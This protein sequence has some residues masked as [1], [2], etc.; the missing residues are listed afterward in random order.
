M[1]RVYKKVKL[2]EYLMLRTKSDAA[3]QKKGGPM[4]SWNTRSLVLAGSALLLAS[5]AAIAAPSDD[6]KALVE[7]GKAG[8]AY[9]LGKKNAAQFGD[10]GFDFY[11][12]IAAVDSG[13]AG[14]GVLALER[15][16]LNYPDNVSARLQLARGYY[17]LGEDARAREE[18][19]ALQKL[20]PPADVAATIARF[21][22]AI[23]LR[24][25][26]YLL[27]AG[28][29]LDLGGGNDSN[30][31]GGVA[32]ADITL[33]NLGPVTVDQ[34]GQKI[35]DNFWLLGLGGYV[36][37]PIA[38]G[39]A[40]FANGQGEAR[41]NSDRENRAFDLGNYNV[42]GGV[43]LLREQ[44]LFRF[45]V[46]GNVITL[47]N[48]RYR[49]SSGAAAEW[50]YQVDQVQS[51]NLGGQYAQL[52]YA[53]PNRVRDAD[54][55]GVSAG[56][57]RLFNNTWQ[58][59]FSLALNGGQEKIRA[60]DRDDLARKLFGARAGLNFTPAAKWGVSAG[61]T[62]LDSKYQAPDV[63]LGVSR[64]DKYY[65]GDAAIVY[66]FTRNLSFHLEALW[67]KNDSNIELYELPRNVYLFKVRYEFK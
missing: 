34:R 27:S 50:Q 8:E 47:D 40:L 4:R 14:E 32:N 26:R 66:L 56:Y 55:W 12:G 57:R 59:V 45:S 19:E 67:S 6:V 33:P 37:K 53:D 5:M 30:V 3:E 43:S 35:R 18:F 9:A 24:E 58:P 2:Q 1:R 13:H 15:Y 11:F 17:S 38:P 60:D 65:A 29:Y 21:L 16:L 25:S 61:V 22:D 64:H 20:N 23:R 10:P 42:A 41:S 7:Q 51:F 28:A 48:K 63:F 31:N 39:I 46:V 36:T 49:S 54:F 44:N 52:R 62:F